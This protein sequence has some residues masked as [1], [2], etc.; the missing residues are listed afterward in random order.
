MQ[1]RCAQVSAVNGSAVGLHL[2]QKE[3]VEGHLAGALERTSVPLVERR[4][5]RLPKIAA[6]WEI[7][8]VQQPDKM[9]LPKHNLPYHYVQAV[10]HER[11]LLER[12]PEQT[13]HQKRRSGA[14]VRVL[15]PHIE[16]TMED[17]P[18]EGPVTCTFLDTLF[19]GL[20]EDFAAL[21]Q[22][23]ASDFKAIKKELEELGQWVEFLKRTEDQREECHSNIRIRSAL[24]QADAGKLEDYVLQLFRHISPELE[25]E[26][27]I[28]DPT[29]REQGDHPEHPVCRR[30]NSLHDFT[31]IG[32]R[33]SSCLRSEIKPLSQLKVQ[34]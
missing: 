17:P 2:K 18:P 32:K 12:F 20:R 24:L 34:N 6:K 14:G 13:P 15:I 19:E 29:H 26:S 1:Q 16:T 31:H 28:L 5:L 10:T 21:G 11:A 9:A 23:V 3:A 27:I 30:I 7:V 25:K 4:H 8:Y 22:D 33:I